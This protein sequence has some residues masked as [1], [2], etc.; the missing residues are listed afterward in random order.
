M[1]ED[2]VKKY[3]Q[4]KQDG[5]VLLG[6]NTVCD[7]ADSNREI[8]IFTHIHRD[9]TELFNRAMHECS[10]IFVSPPTLDLLAALDQ[11]FANNVSTECYFKGRHIHP[12]DFAT[13][14][15]PKI[16]NTYGDKI[17]LFESKHILGSSQVLIE[18]TD[19]TRIV[20][21]GDFGPDATPIPCDILV[22]DSTHGD[23][24]FNTV[25]DR[26]SLERRLV[27]CVE[28]EIQKGKSIMIRA[29]RGRLQYIMHLLSETIPRVI[30]FLS[31]PIDI[32]LINVYEKY[33]MPIR[34][35]INFKSGIG[36]DIHD[37]NTPYVEFRSHGQGEHFLENTG[38]MTVFSMGGRYLGGGTVI[39]HNPSSCNYSLEFMDHANYDSIIDYVVKANP[40]YVVTDHVR[41]KQGKK[42]AKD[43]NTRGFKTVSYALTDMS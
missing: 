42:L 33:G 4:I 25:V 32:N 1:N 17:T 16:N 18:T 23:P 38:K 24:M 7:G 15:M 20:Y 35:C 14:M 22:I 2:T 10:Q 41:G 31:H 29:H 36:Q 27:E 39:R 37:G 26:E 6:N 28:N 5:S 13:P 21:T 11:D 12:L 19:G 40:K 34:K 30:K 3:A 8:G 9:H 43:L